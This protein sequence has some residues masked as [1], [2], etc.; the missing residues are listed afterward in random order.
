MGKRINKAITEARLI[1]NPMTP[2]LLSLKRAAEYMGL[3]V[4]AMR[5]RIWAGQIP[6]V[7]FPGGRKMFVDIQDIEKFIQNNK[8]TIA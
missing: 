8:R 1:P 3:T 6:V 7:Q 5:E 4:W 2:R